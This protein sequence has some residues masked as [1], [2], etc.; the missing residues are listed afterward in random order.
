MKKDIARQIYVAGSFLVTLV[1]NMLANTLPLNWQNTGQISDRFNGI[2]VPAGYIFSIWGLIY[3]GLI[4]YAIY[5][6]LPSQRKNPRLSVTGERI[7]L[8]GIANSA[9]IFLWHYYQFSI[10]LVALLVLL[11]KLIVPTCGWGQVER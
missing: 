4:T 8:G 6:A 11:V 9:W 1:V 3:I 5:Q 10:T 7:A 2:F